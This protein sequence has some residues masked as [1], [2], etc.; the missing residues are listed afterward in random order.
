[1]VQDMIRGDTS[2][3]VT[4]DTSMFSAKLDEL[5]SKVSEM[6]KMLTDLQEIVSVLIEGTP[7]TAGIDIKKNDVPPAETDEV[8]P[9]REI[10]KTAVDKL[11]ARRMLVGK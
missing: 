2:V 9:S 5:E 3:A 11:A 10:P 1:M 8:V 7:P 6:E 4:A